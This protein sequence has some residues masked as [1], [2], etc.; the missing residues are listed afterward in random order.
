MSEIIIEELLG[1]N[2]SSIISGGSALPEAWF[3]SS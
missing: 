3:V 1:V 2:V